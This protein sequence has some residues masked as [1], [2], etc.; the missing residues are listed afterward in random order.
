MYKSEGSRNTINQNDSEQLLFGKNQLKLKDFIREL[1]KVE[2]QT[3]ILK[4]F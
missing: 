3:K 1:E 4:K 2:I